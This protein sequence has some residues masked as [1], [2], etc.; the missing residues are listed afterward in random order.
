MLLKIEVAV[1]TSAGRVG[2]D[3][4]V[5]A[6]WQVIDEI[7]LERMIEVFRRACGWRSD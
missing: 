7:G 4:A 3:V 5:P 6:E 2:F 1:V